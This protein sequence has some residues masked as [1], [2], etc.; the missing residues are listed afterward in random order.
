MNLFRLRG[1]LLYLLGMDV[2]IVVMSALCFVF[3]TEIIAAWGAVPYFL[4]IVSGWTSVGALVGFNW[5][6]VKIHRLQYRLEGI[7]RDKKVIDCL[8]KI[9]AFIDIAD[10]TCKTEEG[11]EMA[12]RM[13]KIV[14]H[15]RP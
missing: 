9:A 13:L 15:T 12:R 7:T 3:G 5:T 10:E 1:D 8:E 2:A 4:L 6:A 14:G 11:R